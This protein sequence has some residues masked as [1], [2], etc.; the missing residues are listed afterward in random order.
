MLDVIYYPLCLG[1]LSEVKFSVFTFYHK[2]SDI[3][4]LVLIQRR[5]AE[6]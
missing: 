2:G 3:Y 1:F 4:G 5:S 6:L